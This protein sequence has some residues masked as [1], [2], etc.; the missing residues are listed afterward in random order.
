MM[1]TTPRTAAVISASRTYTR[2]RHAPWAVRRFTRSQMLTWGLSGG[3]ADTV[4]LI[5]DELV[6]NAVT[7]G[8]G[9][10]VW[11]RLACC[12]G[13]VE[14]RVWDGSPDPPI[15]GSPGTEDEKGRG[16][17]LVEALATRTGSFRAGRGKVVFATVATGGVA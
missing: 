7:H 11:V 1:A 8:A 5:A 3:V 9:D 15:T 12:V 13:E 2:S 16:L 10:Q 6:S 17:V 4:E 14:I